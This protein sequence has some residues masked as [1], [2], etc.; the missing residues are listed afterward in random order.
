VILIHVVAILIQLGLLGAIWASSHRRDDLV[1]YKFFNAQA[2]FC[3]FYFIFFLQEQI[4][5][6]FNDFRFLGSEVLSTADLEGVY[7]LAQTHLILFLTAILFGSFMVGLKYKPTI[8]QDAQNIFGKH[9]RNIELLI[10]I[11]FFLIGLAAAAYLG[12]KFKEIQ[13]ADGLR[14]TLVKSTDGLIATS[15]SFFGNFAFAGLTYICMRDRRY[16]L[17]LAL[18]G[19]FGAAILF[20][21]SRGRLLWPLVITAAMFLTYKN[22]FPA[23]RN[24]IFGIILLLVLV[25]MDPFMQSLRI[26]GRTFDL[27]TIGQSLADI[28]LKRNFDGFA[29]FCVILHQDKL[30]PDF[31]LLATGIRSAFMVAYFPD[32]YARGVA[33][34]STYPGY[35]FL[36]GGGLFGFVLLSFGYG[37]LLSAINRTMRKVQSRWLFLAYM[38]GMTWIAA[39]AGDAVESI[40]K[41]VA[42]TMPGFILFFA[43]RILRPSARSIV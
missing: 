40:D 30:I 42:A 4:F 12:I 10:L 11:A 17:A 34:A 22:S 43:E 33:F 20:T 16:L 14:S 15:V 36:G 1:F 2:F 41:L 9:E 21:G 29:N 19:V 28:F 39:V 8:E 38:F 35:F 3:F 7:G 32:I 23:G 5:Y 6:L 31:S 26:P 25:S 24:L 27:S 37:A 13:G 18:L